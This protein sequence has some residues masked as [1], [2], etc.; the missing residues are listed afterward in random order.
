MEIGHGNGSVIRAGRAGLKSI[1]RAA[2]PVANPGQIAAWKRQDRMP[3]SRNRQVDVQ[4]RPINGSVD[5]SHLAVN[6]SGVFL[7]YKS[8]GAISPT[9]SET[10]QTIA[11][12]GTRGKNQPGAGRY[13]DAAQDLREL[14]S[15]RH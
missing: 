7:P 6:S 2:R 14:S 10:N 3:E 11:A 5:L 9:V 8:T 12:A 15:A 4:L 13:E 1:C